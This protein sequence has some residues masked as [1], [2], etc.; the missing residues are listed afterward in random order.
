MIN[1]MNDTYFDNNEISVSMF[2]L[3]EMKKMKKVLN[4]N[5]L[6]EELKNI[7]SSFEDFLIR[8]APEEIFY[9]LS[10]IKNVVNDPR[11]QSGNLQHDMTPIIGIFFISILSG[12]DIVKSIHNFGK[13]LWPVIISILDIDEEYPSY[14]T[15]RRVLNATETSEIIEVR[16]IWQDKIGIN[17]NIDNGENSEEISDIYINNWIEKA[18]EDLDALIA[19]EYEP[20]V[21]VCAQDGKLMR[22]TRSAV[23]N[24]VAKDVISI[25]DV[26][27][28]EVLA[29]SIVP[30][31]KNEITENPKVVEKLDES[32]KYLISYDAMGCQKD[33]A[34]EIHY[35][36]WFY[37][38]KVKN[39]Q[40]I[41]RRTIEQI[42]NEHNEK[43]LL[44]RSST[45]G[46]HYTEWSFY[47]SDQTKGIEK[48]W[49]GA[50]SV[51]MVITYSER[52]GKITEEES[53]YVM[54]FLDPALFIYAKIM[55]W[56]IEN[57]LHHP[58]DCVF[59]EDKCRVR[60]GN[61]HL[62]LNVM[63]KNAISFYRSVLRNIMEKT[64]SLRSLTEILRKSIF[65]LNKCIK[66]VKLNI[67]FSIDDL[68]D[69]I[70]NI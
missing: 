5:K 14:D 56:K 47:V 7:G 10:I 41:L 21:R 68:L 63:R 46:G 28:N 40:P 33:L 22:A 60:T 52:D 59:N 42:F 54:N 25:Y 34:E 24:E 38:F 48:E 29:E 35:R 39:N 36:G 26:K 58:L 70:V 37:L 55:H 67:K 9:L 15:F 32:F 6:N 20:P 61:G 62:N 51:A 65:S 13:D 11:R 17:Y 30:S 27:T 8:E 16:R 31:K 2:K 64:I 45:E 44:T 3:N 23:N 69:E 4:V 19:G 18:K 12:Y 66:N 50:K 57:Q 1:S 49:A 53:Y 43:P